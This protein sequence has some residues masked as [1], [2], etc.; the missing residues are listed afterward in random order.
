[1]SVDIYGKCGKKKCGQSLYKSTMQA[2]N[3]NS[4]EC[5]NIISDYKFYLAFENSI[6]KKLWRKK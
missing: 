1:M 6:C 5:E 3:V 2:N 4:S